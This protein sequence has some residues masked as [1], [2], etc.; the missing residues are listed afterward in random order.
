MESQNFYLLLILHQGISFR[1]CFKTNSN[2]YDTR[3]KA[4]F[5]AIRTVPTLTTALSI[6]RG[7]WYFRRS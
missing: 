7:F 3:T 5:A 1:Y 4:N 6:V 2:F